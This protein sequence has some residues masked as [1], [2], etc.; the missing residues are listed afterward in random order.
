MRKKKRKI[1][2][3]AP[4][5]KEMFSRVLLKL[6]PPP[7]LTVSEWADKYRRMS[8]EA[9]AGT[10]RWHTDSA[11]Y[12]REIMDAI[13]DPHIRMVVFKSS[14]Q[15]GKTEVL[16]NVL[17]YDIDYT[18]A[19][20]LVLQPTVEMGQTFSKDR[21]APMI[22]D[23]PVLRKK[24]DAKSRFAGNT[25]MQKSFPGGHVTIVGANSPAGLASRPIK[26]VL[27]DEV[28]RYPKSAGTEGDPLTLA[29]T[30]QTTFWDKENGTGFHADHQ[31]RQ[32]H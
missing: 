2:E 31:G 8:P 21:L 30:R 3:V 11:P 6:K 18:P 25:I 32:P 20:T 22:R 12:Q 24:M 13:G 17:G 1:V 9:S 16:L 29:R 19:P 27:A 23:T 15:V 28:D 26:F 5:V 7:K 14:S 4:E 10:G